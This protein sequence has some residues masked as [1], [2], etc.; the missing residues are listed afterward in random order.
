MYNVFKDHLK[1]SKGKPLVSQF[2]S[3]ID[4]QGIYRELKKH[5]SSLVEAQLLGDMLLQ[6]IKKTRFSEN[7]SRKAYDFVL[8][9]RQQVTKYKTHEIEEISPKQKFR[10]LK[11]AGSD[12]PE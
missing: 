5:A 4:A 7:W 8:H 11:H 2:R 3:T 1:T 10:L 9:W 6:D 12:V